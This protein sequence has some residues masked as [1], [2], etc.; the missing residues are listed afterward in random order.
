[1]EDLPAPAR[2]AAQP[3]T[4]PP[5]T[6]AIKTNKIN[7]HRKHALDRLEGRIGA[8]IVSLP[9][10]ADPSAKAGRR[11]TPY[12]GTK[13]RNPDELERRVPRQ[14]N[15]RWSE[16]IASSS[17]ATFETPTLG[18]ATKVVIAYGKPRLLDHSGE[19]ATS[20]TSQNLPDQVVKR[21]Y[22]LE[23]PRNRGR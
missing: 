2:R 22:D 21:G 15:S 20:A 14:V 13:I 9:G 4:R 10:E 11:I 23:R 6:S 17:S 5:E 12:P 8:K 19:R 1:M 18:T 16:S 7:T 3:A